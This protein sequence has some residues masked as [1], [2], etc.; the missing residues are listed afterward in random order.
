MKALAASLLLVTVGC[1]ISPDRA[2]IAVPDSELELF[3][4][5]EYDKGVWTAAD[6]RLIG[7]SMFE[8]STIYVR[9][10]CD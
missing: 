4:P 9:R 7:Y 10:G 5:V 6:D 3:A 1:E 2:C 8:E